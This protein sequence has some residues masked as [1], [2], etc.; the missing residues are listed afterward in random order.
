MMT[1]HTPVPNSTRNANN[2]NGKIKPI[3]RNFRRIRGRGN[4]TRPS[5]KTRTIIRTK[6]GTGNRKGKWKGFTGNLTKEPLK[7]IVVFQSEQQGISKYGSF[8]NWCN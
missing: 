7:N 4:R 3:R 1:T 2:S 5:N 6:T 8:L